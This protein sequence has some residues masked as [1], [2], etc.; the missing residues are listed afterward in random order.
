MSDLIACAFEGSQ[1][2]SSVGMKRDVNISPP[3]PPLCFPS[4]LHLAQR[5]P[6]PPSGFT[7]NATHVSMP[8][9]HSFPLSPLVDLDLSPLLHRQIS[10]PLISSLM[11]AR[12]RSL[13][14]SA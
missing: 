2:T 11:V 5:S 9:I 10:M 12:D 8:P 4:T 14:A 3:S 1:P 13:L 6:I 7:F